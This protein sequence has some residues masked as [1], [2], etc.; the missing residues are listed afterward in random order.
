MLNPKSYR[1]PS[2]NESTAF[3]WNILENKERYVA[4]VNPD[5]V[6]NNT[7]VQL[8]NKFSKGIQLTVLGF[9]NKNSHNNSV[10]KDD[11]V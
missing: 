3:F 10:V 6:L 9:S 7:K 1:R 5:A 8:A 11:K 2:L 4:F